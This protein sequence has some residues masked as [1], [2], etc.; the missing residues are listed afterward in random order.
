[1]WEAGKSTDYRVIHNHKNKRSRLRKGTKERTW[2]SSLT[3][4]RSSRGLLTE[5]L[6]V[7]DEGEVFLV[8]N[9]VERAQRRVQGHLLVRRVDRLRHRVGAEHL[10]L[11]DFGLEV[12]K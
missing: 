6:L 1:M 8:Q 4:R 7:H 12:A 3:G 10:S 11:Q 9:A 5:S 2:L